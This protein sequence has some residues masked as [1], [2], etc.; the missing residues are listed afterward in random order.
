MIP[1][2]TCPLSAAAIL[3][4]GKARRFGGR[5][6]SRLVV[7]GLP[8]IVRQMQVLT[9]VAHPVFVVAPYADRFRDLGLEVYP[10]LI[11][12]IGAIGG[13]YTALERSPEESVIV[14]ACDQPFLDEDVLRRLVE[15]GGD[16]DGAWL[17]TPKGVEP[18]IACYRRQSL[19]AIRGEID[20]GR[21]KLADLEQVLDMR[22]LDAREVMTDR[23]IE[24]LVA[25]INTPDDY[26][27]IQ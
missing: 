16:A 8:I 13:L 14:V 22:G 2:V 1:S 27:R 4:G 9:R 26:A 3:A 25:N 18:L 5:D 19:A 6:K 7:E 17:R 23:A 15:L 24:R 21:L 20:A 11:P 10:D 12:D